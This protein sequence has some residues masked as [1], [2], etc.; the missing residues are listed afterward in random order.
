MD[1]V[2]K[3]VETLIRDNKIMVCSLALLSR[4]PATLLAGR[5]AKAKE[6]FCAV[7]TKEAFE[8]LKV[9]YKAIELDQLENGAD[10]QAYLAEI[11][12]QRTVPN[13]FINGKHI[14]GNSDLQAGIKEGRIQRLLTEVSLVPESESSSSSESPVPMAQTPLASEDKP[15]AQGKSTL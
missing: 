12:K 7:S 14:G 3:L 15:I 2:K 13:I 5:T 11:S 8:K 9:R 1:T 6:N 10:I 4:P